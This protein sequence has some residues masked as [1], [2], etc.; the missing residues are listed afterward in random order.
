MIATGCITLK[1]EFTSGTILMHPV[2]SD[3]VTNLGGEHDSEL[4]HRVKFVCVSGHGRAGRV[5]GGADVITRST[6]Q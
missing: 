1:S 6:I 4:A 2:F 5:R 3:R